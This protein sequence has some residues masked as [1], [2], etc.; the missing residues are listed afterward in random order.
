VKGGQTGK[1]HGTC[2]HNISTHLLRRYINAGCYSELC[3]CAC[4]CCTASKVP[5]SCTVYRPSASLHYNQIGCRP[6]CRAALRAHSWDCWSPA[7]AAMWARETQRRSHCANWRRA[8]EGRGGGDPLDPPYGHL[9]A[10]PYR[11][12]PALRVRGQAVIGVNEISFFSF[13]SIQPGT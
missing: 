9:T 7:S 3:I 1:T 4:T 6:T 5:C 2:S 10:P 8:G 11:A 12:R 13:F